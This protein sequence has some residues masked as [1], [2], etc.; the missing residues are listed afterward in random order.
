MAQY[1]DGPA[2]FFSSTKLY[3]DSYHLTFIQGAY[4]T[5]LTTQNR[6]KQIPARA[7]V[8]ENSFSPYC[9]KEWSKLSDKIRNIKSINKF[10]VTILNFIWPKGNSVFDIHDTKRIKLLSHLRWS[11][12][13]LNEHKFRHNFNNMV[14][15]MCTCGRE[16]ET[17]LHYLLRWNLYSAQ[18]LE[19]LNNV[20]ILNPSL[21]NYSNE[22]LSNI[23]LYGSE[24]F[25]CNMNKKILKAAIKFLKISERFNGPFFWL[26]LRWLAWVIRNWYLRTNFFIIW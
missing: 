11:F 17:T 3:R 8:F 24:D 6:I 16:P 1:K 25:N 20:C 13:R 18:R 19:L 7:K 23:L 26:C 2:G 4:L 10:K 21:K 9:I 5:R 22:K 12:S 15:P 14:D